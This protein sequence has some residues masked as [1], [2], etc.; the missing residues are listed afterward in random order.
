MV[1][2]EHYVS[3]ALVISLIEVRKVIEK[4]S[5]RE[6]YGIIPFQVH[7]QFIDSF[8]SK[9]ESICLDIFDEAERTLK[10]VVESFCQRHFGRFQTSGLLYEVR[11][12][13]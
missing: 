5:I 10:K 12:V 2:F 7:E 13:L 6:L 4:I 8:V 1:C 3:N 9:W 11:Y